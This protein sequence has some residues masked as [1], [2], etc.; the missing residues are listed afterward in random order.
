M[1]NNTNHPSTTSSHLRKTL[2]TALLLAGIGQMNVAHAVNLNTGDIL[3]IT[4]GVTGGSYGY[5]TGGSYFVPDTNGNGIFSD[6][7]RSPLQQGIQ[8]ILVGVAQPT[9]ISHTGAPTGTEG[10]TID[11]AWL[12]F[13]NTG[14]HFTVSPITGG[15]TTGLDF[16]GW[17]VTWAGIPSLFL[18]GG[19]QDCG[20]ST[21]GICVD[22]TSSS[23][24]AGTYNNG[25]GIATFT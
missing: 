24:I 10:G 22:L 16:S 20:T 14:M 6:F 25:T 5:V 7:E 12:Y 23:D 1:K 18:G 8:G 3:T 9:G 21:D 17:S 11:A 4:A 2:V 15:T 19:I 13:G